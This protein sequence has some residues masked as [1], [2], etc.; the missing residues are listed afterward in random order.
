MTIGFFSNPSIS[1]PASSFIVKSNGPTTLP[2]PRSRSQASAAPSNACAASWSSSHSK[3][4]KIPQSWPWCSLKS[5]SIW[6]LIRPTGVRPRQ[7][8]KSCASPCS[9][10]GFF[11]G[12]RNCLRSKMSGGTHCG[13]LR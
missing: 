4:P 5:R 8:M 1:T 3:K 13:W 6:A 9:K 7:A 10:N 2:R 11:L 12:L